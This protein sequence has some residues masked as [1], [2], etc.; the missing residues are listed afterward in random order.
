M[1]DLVER[2]RAIDWRIAREAADEIERLHAEFELF[3]EAPS[4]LEVA[5]YE[6]E[7]LRGEIE[8]HEE[9]IGDLFGRMDTLKAEIERLRTALKV[10]EIEMKVAQQVIT[11]FEPPADDDKRK[12]G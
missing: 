7:R 12:G 6:I 5:Q 3:R 1:T 2:L 10:Y 11:N 8:E 4:K 9:T